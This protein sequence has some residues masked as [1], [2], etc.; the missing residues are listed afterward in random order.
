MKKIMLCLLL[1]PLFV[2]AKEIKYK[3]WSVRINTDPITDE[4]TVSMTSVYVTDSTSISSAFFTVG[5][6]LVVITPFSVYNNL[7][8]YED[9]LIKVIFR[10]DK[11]APVEMEWKI[12]NGVLITNQKD[13]LNKEIQDAKKFIIRVGS[14]STVD[15]K[16]PLAGYK[17][18]YENLEKECSN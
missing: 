5:C 1:F 6:D 8:G 16:F 17:K 9:G 7:K 14:K 2:F 3:E 15:L 11:K 13:F 4:K 18:A 12:K 10:A